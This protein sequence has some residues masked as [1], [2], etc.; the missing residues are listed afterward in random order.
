[1]YYNLTLLGN[2]LKSAGANLLI[3]LKVNCIRL[4]PYI[5]INMPFYNKKPFSVTLS[6]IFPILF[7]YY[8]LVRHNHW[9]LID[10]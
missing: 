4:V 1:M 2:F 7:P 8:K 10:C 3:L 6:I 9:A 5:Y